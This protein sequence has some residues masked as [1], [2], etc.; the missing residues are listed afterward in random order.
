ML[1]YDK[2][3]TQIR[4]L[5]EKSLKR[6]FA[7]AVHFGEGFSRNIRIFNFRTKYCRPYNLFLN[8][9]KSLQ[10]FEENTKPLIPIIVLIVYCIV[11]HEKD[12][13]SG[14]FLQQFVNPK[15]LT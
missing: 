1:L 10:R 9:E 6:F 14:H 8:K 13:I 15:S 11:L 4:G 2:N 12:L 3:F 5:K 7:L